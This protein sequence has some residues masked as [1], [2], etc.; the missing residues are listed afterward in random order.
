MKTYLAMLFLAAA[1]AW[2]WA[3]PEPWLRTS[4]LFDRAAMT[5][6]TAGTV[7][8]TRGEEFH[9]SVAIEMD[10]GYHVNAHD[11]LQ[12]FQIPTVLTPQPAAG[13]RWGEVRYPPGQAL[14]PKGAEGESLSVYAGR[15]Y[16][17][18]GGVTA[19]DAPLG[20][21]VLRLKLDYQGCGEE[22]C[23]PPSSRDLAATVRVV[24]RGSASAADNADVFAEAENVSAARARSVAAPAIHYE[25]QADLSAQFER[26]PAVY[27]VSLLLFGLLLNLTPCVF[28]L[29]PV[30][31]TFFAQQ[32]ESRPAKVLPLAVLYVL[33]LATTFTVVGVAA[34]LAGRSMGLVLQS[35]AGVLGVVAIMAIMMAGA[36]GAFDMRL[37]SGLAGRLGGRRG[38]LGAIL[39][40]M[41]MGLVASPCVGPFLVAL[42]AFVATQG[43]VALGAASFFATGLG[44]G[45]PYLFL[46]TFTG[47]IN[48]FP[49]GGGWLV[50]A[51]RVLG[52]TMAGLILY[53]VRPFIAAAFFWPIVL[54]T[55]IF[56]GIYLGVL[57]GFSRRPFSRTFWAVRL[58]TGAAILAAGFFVYTSG[59][60]ARP[61]IPWT[62]WTPGALEA[63]QAEHKP[64]LLYFGA[65]WCLACHEWHAGL[66]ADSAV[67]QETQGFARLDVDLTK[68][69]EGPRKEL[70]QQLDAL[71]PPA[72]IVFDR[73]GGIVRAWRNPPTREEFLEA[74][75]DADRPLP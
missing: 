49:R 1:S 20:P 51:K 66:F 75:G 47:L 60:A 26:G 67:I 17:V 7:A 53:Y 52:M 54:A 13:I 69:P 18:L 46:G 72:V 64:V 43:S 34:A 8:L 40:G 2:S 44:L 55:F 62:P 25:E 36:F 28:P 15:T 3:P 6:G 65:D 48:R 16:L 58:A 42:I 10:E 22:V 27:F 32:G 31:M 21:L 11:G 71:N 9:V 63:A 23:F 74:L 37:P 29:V 39:M 14:S 12:A 57:E 33:G 59:A 38:A 24:E 68:P 70:A 5:A 56:A 41:V 4:V 45:L 35:P 73:L 50:W 61:E 19:D 30:T